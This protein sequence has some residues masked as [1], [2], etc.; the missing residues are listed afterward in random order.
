[1]LTKTI[2]D[3]VAGAIRVLVCYLRKQFTSLPLH[4]QHISSNKSE[5]DEIS[6]TNPYFNEVRS[7]QFS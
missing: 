7:G 1:M 2:M 4:S 3:S 6:K 5:G